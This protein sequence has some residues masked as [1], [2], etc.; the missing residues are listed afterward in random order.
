VTAAGIASGQVVK[1]IDGL[2]DA[3]IVAGGANISVT[4]VGNNITI[5]STASGGG[6][7][8]NG[9]SLAGNAGTATTNFLGTTDYQNLQLKVY[10]QRALLLQ[11]TYVTNTPNV[12]GGSSLNSVS[13][14][15][16][17]IAGGYQ[18]IIYPNYG[19]IGGGTNCT[20]A[21]AS[22]L[23]FIG[24]GH[25]NTIGSFAANGFIGGGENNF[26]G[27]GSDAIAGGTANLVTS[28][29]YYSAIGG[30]QGNRIDYVGSVGTPQ[31]SDIGGGFSNL[32]YASVSFVGGGNYN[33]IKTPDSVIAGGYSNVDT[34]IAY[35]GDSGF[36]TVS[37]GSAN[38]AS[39][40]GAT[41]PGGQNNTASGYDSFAAGID[42]SALND[43][44][45][46]WGSGGANGITPF[47]STGDDQ[48]LMGPNVSVG[49]NT[50]DPQSALD[51][52]GSIHTSGTLF[53]DYSVVVGN[54]QVILYSNGNIQAEN[55][56]IAENDINGFQVN[57]TFVYANTVYANG[58]AL[59]SD[60]NA[61]ENFKPVDNQAVLAKVASLPVTE[62]NYKTQSKDVQHIGPMAQ[63]FQAAF[64]LDGA[65]DKHISVVDEG[66]VAL[67]AI[68]G[69]N[70]KLEQQDKDKDAEIQTLKQQNDSLAKRLTE[71]EAAVKSLAQQK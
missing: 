21:A 47:A 4:S 18:N 28:G 40:I 11:P 1:S 57:A 42:A 37:G 33:V 66:G 52:N 67:A 17:T 8:T 20:I 48:F 56:I 25:G 70:E 59:T 49:I 71:L 26:I 51:V 27:G 68:Q 36:D 12:I 24:G 55:N 19:F 31:Q 64:G 2:H 46:V 61:K 60:R 15:G 35:A 58:V 54:S 69:L 41:V 43:H 38:I 34:Y 13:G 14:I 44:S 50:N 65:D 7:N 10:G 22:D 16:D 53:A 9:W 23:C 39:G 62:W 29:A 32:V 30:G 5:A 45:F 63:D 6:G 3:V